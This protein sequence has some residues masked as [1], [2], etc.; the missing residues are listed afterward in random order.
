MANLTI[1][2]DLPGVTGQLDQII[3]L[4]TAILAEEKTMDAATQASLDK[5]NLAVTEQ[6][7]VEASVETLLTGLSAQIAALK[8]G[9]TNPA[10]IAALD[11]A[12]A[13]ITADNTKTAAA[14][15]ANTPA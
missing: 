12:T 5:L 14:V 13:I 11:A 1:T 10:V 2:L 15:V 7:T 4:L 9:V 6:T 3:T 8:A